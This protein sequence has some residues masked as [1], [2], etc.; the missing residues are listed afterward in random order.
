MGEKQRGKQS[1][2]KSVQKQ[3]FTTS[4]AGL[5]PTLTFLMLFLKS[6]YPAIH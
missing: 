6:G 4:L 5:I 1:K 2:G 3:N